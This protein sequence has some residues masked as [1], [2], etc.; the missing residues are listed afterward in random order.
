MLF[1]ISGMTTQSMKPCST[2][3]NVYTGGASDRLSH[4]SFLIDW[5]QPDILSDLHGSISRYTLIIINYAALVSG[6][7]R[8][9]T[10][11]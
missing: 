9:I 10:V 6:L 11:R 1:S 2:I 8:S 7:S 4:D 3:H 5:V